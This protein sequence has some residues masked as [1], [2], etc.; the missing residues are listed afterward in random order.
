MDVVM[1]PFLMAK[2]RG[3]GTFEVQVWHIFAQ[4]F[5][6]DIIPYA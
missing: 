5:G 4:R 1:S 6:I 2:V 3:D